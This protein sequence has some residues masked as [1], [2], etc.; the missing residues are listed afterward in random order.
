MAY[1]SLANHVAKGA[2]YLL[3]CNGRECGNMI[4]KVMKG[5][6]KYIKSV[7]GQLEE[8]NIEISEM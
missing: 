4:E 6:K 3:I 8:L 5:Q 1:R 7:L 2:G